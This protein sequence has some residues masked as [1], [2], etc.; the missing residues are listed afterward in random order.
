MYNTLAA[1]KLVFSY[2]LLLFLGSKSNNSANYHTEMNWDAFSHWCETKV[3]PDTTV[4]VQKSIV[5][6]Y[7]ATYHTVLPEDDRYHVTSLNEYHISK[8]KK[9]WGR[10]SNLINAKYHK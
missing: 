6:L 3:F 1:Q 9:Q 10:Y 5:V 7:T 2:C 4:T 8:S